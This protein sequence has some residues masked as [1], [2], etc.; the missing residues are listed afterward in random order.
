[1]KK[2]DTKKIIIAIISLVVSIVISKIGDINIQD[3]DLTDLP[4]DMLEDPSDFSDFFED[5]N[6][7]S[8][9]SQSDNSSEPSD[10]EEK[11]DGEFTVYYDQ[12][13]DL[14]KKIY[15]SM[16]KAV[17]KAE[18]KVTLSNVDINDFERECEKAGVA[19]Q[20]DHPEY[21]W[22]TGGFRYYY[23]RG[24]TLSDITVEPIY[25]EYV[26]GFFDE[27]DKL[28]DL[29]KAVKNV[30]SLA[31]QHSNDDYERI[32]FVHDYLIKNA[33]YDHD[34]LNEYYKTSRS[35]SCEYIF[36]SYGCLVNGKTVCSGYAK[37]FQLIMRELGYDSTYV[38]GDAGERHGWNCVYLDGEGYFVDVTWDDG[39]L[40]TEVPFYNYAFITDEMLSRTHKIDM[41]FKMPA[42]T[43]TEYNYFIKNGYYLDK[44]NFNSASAIISKQVNNDAA[45][46]MFGSK[47]ELSKAVK[48]LCDSG[49]INKISGIKKG[50]YF[51]QNEDHYTLTFIF[52]S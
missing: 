16:E 21:F 23:S 3:F 29:K 1:M 15:A 32:I 22:F 27:E 50:T 24:S 26:S 25:Y 17:S 44:Y 31:K 18:S 48:D 5:L 40:K 34:A 43:E 36:S 14:Q 42:C 38:V 20:Y 6:G 8:D 51:Y 13:T 11:N 10:F 2:L 19:L 45:Y 7:S 39:D 35:P 33:I 9:N 52:K 46:I 47:Y 12:L 49:R 30:S 28:N 4:A 37:A 41:P